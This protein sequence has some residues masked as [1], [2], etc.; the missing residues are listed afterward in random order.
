VE[1]RNGEKERRD[2]KKRERLVSD[3]VRLRGS[4]G[5]SLVERDWADFGEN[6]ALRLCSGGLRL[7]GQSVVEGFFGLR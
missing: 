7:V 1:T 2:N 6:Y 5:F 3:S 4:L